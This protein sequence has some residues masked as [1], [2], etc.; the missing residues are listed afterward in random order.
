MELT[1]TKELLPSPRHEELF[2]SPH[3][4]L[5]EKETNIPPAH[6]DKRVY[7]SQNKLL[8]ISQQLHNLGEGTRGQSF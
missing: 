7:R 6:S 4:Q 8:T 3:Q 5:Q 1:N 2:H